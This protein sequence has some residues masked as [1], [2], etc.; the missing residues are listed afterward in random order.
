MAVTADELKR[1]Q[2]EYSNGNPSITDEEYDN[3]LEEYLNEHGEENRPFLRAK[4]SDSVNDIVGTLT[5]VYGVTTPMREGQKTYTQWHDTKIGNDNVSIIVQPKFDG[6]SIAYDFVTQ[7]FYTRGDYDNG[8]SVDVTELFKNHIKNEADIV[9]M[10]GFD[11]DKI[12]HLISAKF[13][14]IMSREMFDQLKPVKTDGSSYKRARDVVSA[15]ISSRN[16]DM[17]KYITLVP[18]RVYCDDGICIAPNVSTTICEIT[19]SDDFHTISRFI[20]DLLKNEAYIEY[21]QQSYACDGVVVSV[22]SNEQSVYVDPDREVAIKIL[23]NVKE[24]KLLTVE[25]Q[26]GKTGRITPVAILEPVKFDNI[27]VDHAGLSTLD[28][29]VELNLRVGDTVRIVHNIVPYFLE[30][31]HDGVGAPII[32]PNKCPVCGSPLDTKILKQVR[33]TNNDC[34]GLK[35][36]S[37]IRYCEK[38]KMFGVS[39][40]ILTKMFDVGMVSNIPDLYKIEMDQLSQLPSFGVTSATNV[41]SSIRT[42]STNVSLDRWLGALPIRDTSAKIWKM[43]LAATFNSNEHAVTEVKRMITTGSPEDMIINLRYPIGVGQLKIQKIAE[44][45]RLNW[46]EIRETI[47]HITFDTSNMSNKQTK[48]QIAMTGT[49]DAA[50][51]EYLTNNGYDVTSFNTKVV[52]LIIPT[53]DFVSNKVIAAKEKGIPVYTIEEAYD[54]L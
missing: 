30:S 1:Y 12:N 17:T 51:T 33:C 13:E 20:D 42:S 48:G 37:V 23:N 50:L 29:V 41:I 25:F 31:C 43:I 18:L 54:K 35:I 45:L 19:K 16:F 5:K 36:G 21:R 8:E 15:T 27:T 14:A 28:R 24:T 39:K 53:L 34:P 4:Q 52:A 6:C 2:I 11:H 44:G 47:P 26:F 9:E 7:R 3:L 49:R 38:M 46:D 22:L 40:G 32:I 10:F